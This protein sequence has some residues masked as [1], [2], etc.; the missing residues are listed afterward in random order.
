MHVSNFSLLRGGSKAPSPA[1]S[2]FS[3]S[4]CVVSSSGGIGQNFDESGAG[5]AEA[6][7]GERTFKLEMGREPDDDGCAAENLR[8]EHDRDEHSAE[9]AAKDYLVSLTTEVEAWYE[10]VREKI[11]ATARD[12][13]VELEE[14][15]RGRKRNEELKERN[16]RAAK[17]IREHRQD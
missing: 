12:L 16:R 9:E 11:S 7:E 4:G 15:A 13:E 5:P 1:P 14:L 6:A 10:T 17:I 8:E 3:S 2:L